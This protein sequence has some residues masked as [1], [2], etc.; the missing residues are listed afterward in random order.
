MGN[1]FHMR[2]DF[3]RPDGRVSVFPRMSASKN[4]SERPAEGEWDVFWRNGQRGMRLALC[5][6]HEERALDVRA[7]GQSYSTC[8]EPVVN[9][10]SSSWT[11]LGRR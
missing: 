6:S 2:N 11:S 5:E 8:P 10:F 1:L 4:G 3:H 9:R 7:E